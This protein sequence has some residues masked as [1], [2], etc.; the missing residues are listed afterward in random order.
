MWRILLGIALIA[1]GA[2]T[3]VIG[4][5]YASF[6]MPPDVDALMRERYRLYSTVFGYASYVLF[7]GGFIVV[8]WAVRRHNK[9]SRENR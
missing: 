5:Q 2:A 8:I 3:F 9:L 6:A 7:L 4:L 1:L